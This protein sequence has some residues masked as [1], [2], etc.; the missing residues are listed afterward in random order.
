MAADP[1][2]YEALGPLSAA[3]IASIVGGDVA[4]DASREVIGLAS[5]AAAQAGD[6]F[7][8]VDPRSAGD[9]GGQGATVLVSD[10]DVASSLVRQGHSAILTATPRSALVKAA[11]HLV[12]P[13]LHGG[14]DLISPEADIEEGSHLSPGC[15]VAAHA[16]I[17]AGAR[18][19]AGAVIGPGVEIGAGASIGP[20]ASIN[21]AL[22]G[23]R[24]VIG[25]GAV[26]GETGF[27]LVHE[28]GQ[29][30]TLPHVGRVVIE[31][32]VTL[33]ANV[34]VDRGMFDD[35]RLK[36]GCRIDNLSHIAH[37]VV[38]GEHAVMAAFAGISG[39]VRIGRGVQCGGRVGIADHL[40]IGD[41]ARL[42]ADAAVMRDIPAGETWA[43][44]PAQPIREFMR[45]TAWLRRE[46]G[47]A[48]K[49]SP[50]GSSA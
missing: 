11:S 29:M 18:I 26:I 30:L 50:G 49:R 7:F 8:L 43:G 39:S 37:N 33:G 2:F 47:R 4:G 15:I 17:A 48:R 40:K 14:E 36:T 28:N 1:R 19:G 16:R 9:V 6:L 25:A 41:G 21:F 31:D 23:C 20:R 27:G 45:E 34:T 38:V 5:P 3:E 32:D 35:T 24:A 44:S 46:S 10:P 12:R 42:G 13:R 22:I